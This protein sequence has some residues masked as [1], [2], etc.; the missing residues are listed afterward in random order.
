MNTTQIIEATI[1]G[2]AVIGLAVVL[3]LTGV[4]VAGLL[5]IGALGTLAALEAKGRS[6]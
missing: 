6:Y 2:A 1:A 3:P 4:M 5:I